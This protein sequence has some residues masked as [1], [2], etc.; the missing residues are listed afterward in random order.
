MMIFATSADGMMREFGFTDVTGKFVGFVADLQAGMQTAQIMQQAQQAM[1][2]NAQLKQ[3]NGALQQQAQMT[4]Q[5]NESLSQG[6]SDASGKATAA[7]AANFHL[8]RALAGMS[9]GPVIGPGA[10]ANVAPVAYG[11]NGVAPA[12]P[13]Q[14]GGGQ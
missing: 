1:Q 9:P 2:E 7:L 4:G 11:G 3:Q 14:V 10:P 12:G 8:R 6:L 13:G 5:Q